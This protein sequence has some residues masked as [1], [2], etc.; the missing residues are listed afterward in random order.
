MREELVGDTPIAR[1]RARPRRMLPVVLLLLFPA[2]ADP[3]CAEEAPS[4]DAER[5]RARLDSRE[6]F[7]VPDAAT[8]LT[9]DVDRP[10]LCIVDSARYEFG[11]AD[12][13]ASSFTSACENDSTREPDGMARLSREYGIDAARIA[14]YKRLLSD[15]FLH[16]SPLLRKWLLHPQLKTI[17]VLVGS[18]V[19]GV[20]DGVV[21]P[22]RSPAERPRYI[23]ALGFNAAVFEA[24]EARG[25]ET[26]LGYFEA[27]QS[28]RGGLEH[29]ARSLVARRRYERMPGGPAV[30]LSLFDEASGRAIRGP[31]GIL[32]KIAH[33]E[34]GHCM[35]S[36]VDPPALGSRV[37]EGRD[38]YVWG[39]AP[40][41]G[42]YRTGMLKRESDFPKLV[43]T[44]E[45]ASHVNGDY[46]FESPAMNRL[47][48]TLCFARE[49]ACGSK[50][51]APGDPAFVADL[52]ATYRGTGLLTAI[53]TWRPDEVLCEWESVL[54]LE[55]WVKSWKVFP[56]PETS[57]RF[58]DVAREARGFRRRAEVVRYIEYRREVFRAYLEGTE[59]GR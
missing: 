55:R 21:V 52:L 20:S 59:V 18:G 10:F 35:V 7:A 28:L 22:P 1:G 54:A 43:F 57:R 44:R 8:G 23:Y 16:A 42:P 41:P 33:H 26:F 45:P 58:V 51:H 49:A 5:F 56:A 32:L 50:R 48:D 15:T 11:G 3:V 27:F 46:A 17:D 31:V 39:D 40:V 9:R 38:V 25:L 53:S 36:F 29:R 24:D 2:L 30:S 13:E 37:V 14:G 12:D 34:L 19:N 4:P 6:R 47:R